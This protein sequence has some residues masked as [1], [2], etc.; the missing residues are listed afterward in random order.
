MKNQ[1]V[2]TRCGKSMTFIRLAQG[3]AGN[4]SPDTGLEQIWFCYPRT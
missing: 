4:I 1:E 2:L 3:H